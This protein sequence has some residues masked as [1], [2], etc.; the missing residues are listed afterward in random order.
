MRANGP[1]RS[2]LFRRNE[3]SPL[4]ISSL[5]LLF[6]VLGVA[7]GG[8]HLYNNDNDNTACSGYLG[9][10]A[11]TAT[12]GVPPPVDPCTGPTVAARPINQGCGKPLPARQVAT[13]KGSPMG[14]THWTVEGTGATLGATIPAKKGPRTFWVRVPQDYDPNHKYRTVYVGQGCGGYNV[15]NL[16]TLQ[17][18]SEKNGGTEEAIYVALDIPTDKANMDCYDN[19]DGPASQEWEAFQIIHGLVDDTYCVD[20][21]RVYST[22][23]STGGWLQNM[24]GCY[25]AGDGEHPWNGVPQAI[26][27]SS[28]DGVSIVPRAGGINDAGASDA[29]S[30]DAGD[31]MSVDST[32]AAG[33]GGA[34]G[35]AGTG[36]STGAAGDATG[37]AG[38]GAAGSSGGN[39]CA[40][41][42]RR[43]AREYHIRAQ[44]GVSGGEPD[45]NPPCNGPVAAM[46][47]HDKDDANPYT[48]NHE[49][50]LTRVLK[51]N[52]CYSTTPTTAPWHA[53]QTNMD[54]CVKYTD[55]P[56]AYPVVFCTSVGL[57]HADQHE[58]AVP[59]FKWFFDEVEAGG[60]LGNPKP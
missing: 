24:W 5:S 8:C 18:F 59:G 14:Y 20:N 11:H 1:A 4:K 43:F 15:A 60:K 37:A 35:A 25:F 40:G 23:Y 34:D 10:S 51:M 55:C 16:S 31:A 3:E 49:V 33:A 29:T 58:T 50:A 45:N 9:C 46:W 27:S 13:V 53:G 32:G 17:L 7:L 39:S 6:G 44:A 41:K 21:D 30:T 47:I 28:A 2:A 19:R 52:G 38:S 48:A 36:G 26:R 12:L 22:G 42:P 54:V 56:A 57:G